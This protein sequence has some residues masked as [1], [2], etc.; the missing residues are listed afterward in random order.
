[1]A[2]RSELQSNND[3]HGILTVHFVLDNT[4]TTPMI[5]SKQ[6]QGNNLCALAFTPRTQ[7]QGCLLQ[8]THRPLPGRTLCSSLITQSLLRQQAPEA[9]PLR[10][11]VAMKERV[12]TAEASDT[13]N[14]PVKGC[15]E[16]SRSPKCYLLSDKSQSNLPSNPPAHSLRL[17]GLVG[18]RADFLEIETSSLGRKTHHCEWM[19]P[20]S[21]GAVST[22]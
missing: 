14:L 10:W 15:Q 9:D 2:N 17:A 12:E 7:P 3:I 16:L 22:N 8:G 11:R 4:L 13:T 5:K 20:L 6:N 18:P 21:S 1:M 19:Q